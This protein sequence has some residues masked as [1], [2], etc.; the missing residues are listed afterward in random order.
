MKKYW[1][2]QLLMYHKI[3][4]PVLLLLILLLNHP[5]ISQENSMNTVVTDSSEHGYRT[6]IIGSEYNKSPAY[7]FFWGRH[8]RKEWMTPVR[9]PVI[10]LDTIKGGLTATEQGGGRQTTT[11]RLKDKNGREYVLRS[12]NKD[13]RAALP[14]IARGTFIENL[15]KDHV[16]TAHP[17]SAITVPPMI[18]AA[19]IYH[20]N[21]IIV[22]VPYT[23]SLGVFNGVFANTVCLFEERPD[24]D[25]SDADFFGRSG[26]IVGTEKMLEK[27]YEKNDHRVIQESFVRAR[28]FDM[29]LGDWGR[30]EDQW[31]WAE[32]ENNG[33]T[34]YKPIP[35]DRDQMWTK[36]DGFITRRI[37]G[38][39]ALEHLQTFDHRIRNIKKYNFP[40]RYL[41]R[42]LTNQESRE[43]WMK[44]AAELKQILT[45]S[46]IE[47]SIRQIPP[48]IYKYSGEEITAKLKSRRNDLLK[49]AEKYYKFIAQE[50]DIVGSKQDELFVINKLNRDE[51]QIN[52][53]DL[54]KKGIP[55][56]RPFYARKFYATQTDEVNIYGLQGNDVYRIEGAAH[57]R[58]IIRIIGGTDRDS[59]INHS[60][61]TAKLKYFDNP[62]NY[63][64]GPLRQKISSDTAINSFNYFSYKYNQGS[65][66]LRPYY[67]NTRGIN[68]QFGYDYTKQLWRKQPFGW[69]QALY[70]Y[71]S[72]TN[73]SWGGDYEA[74]FNQLIGQWNLALHANYDQKLEQYF[75]GFGNN[76][77]FESEKNDYQYY[78]KEAG[79][80][81]GL[82]RMIGKHHLVG[83]RGFYQSV[84]I[85]KEGSHI[86]L[87]QAPFNDPETY[88]PSNFTG[89][90]VHYLFHYYNEEVVPTKGFQLAANLQRTFNLNRPEKSFNRASVIA[91]FYLPLTKAFSLAIR[92][93]GATV[94]GNPEFY[95][96]AHL[97]GG[98]TLRGY[99]RQRFHGRT[100]FH[101]GNDLR[102]IFNTRNSVFNGKIGIIA[103]FDQGKVWQP[104]D[105]TNQ[106]HT[107]YGGGLMIAPFNKLSVTV[108]Y[109]MSDE[110]KRFHIRLGTLF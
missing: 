33:A 61:S 88:E 99:F 60:A 62:G 32:F 76:T 108:Y 94:T 29:F 81:A 12:V 69:Y 64:R 70:G 86:L 21:P 41:D 20:T 109:G 54:D 46:L 98:G 95:Q 35:R 49:I 53:F 48:E 68:I 42:Q 58:I 78:S 4:F 56:D 22:F 72:I 24:E 10:N 36:F 107:G 15:A 83:I 16:S 43:T 3:K 75:F 84:K 97:G 93:G 39:E 80:S 40:P 52:I 26:N 59:V 77:K 34:V 37:V 85:L 18:E 38:A 5:C 23:P 66:I 105:N 90:E 100:T 101:N 87:P 74:L 47:S 31:R 92:A 6:V 63:T 51:L 73:K 44:Q 57:N 27:I 30:H 102:Y 28:L 19:G 104:A 106:W 1:F 11:L 45:D 103:F 17:F 7:R 82:H 50:I 8:Y 67:T 55:A 79:G 13:Y 9:V 89:A 91:G 25:W 110:T 65:K 71:Y 2:T 14:E 96:L